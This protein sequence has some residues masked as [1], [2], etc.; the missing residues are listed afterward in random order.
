MNHIRKELVMIAAHYGDQIK[1]QNQSTSVILIL[2][3]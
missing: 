1:A 2:I 3:I